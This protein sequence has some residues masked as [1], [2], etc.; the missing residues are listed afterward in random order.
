[1]P[2]L[3]NAMLKHGLSL[4]ILCFLL[5]LVPASA[6][7]RANDDYIRADRLG[8]AHISSDSGTSP[9]RYEQALRLGAGWNRWPLYWDRVERVPGEREWAAYDEQVRNDLEMGLQINAILIGVPGA[10]Q[11]GPRP[12]GI[13]SRSSPM[14]LTTPV[15]ARR[16]TRLTP[17]GAL[18]MPPSNAIN[19]AGNSQQGNNSHLGRA[20]ACGRSGTNRISRCSGRGVHGITHD[21][22]R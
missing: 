8:I 11:D 10:Y 5:A 15:P 1:M 19:R 22:S 7:Q 2:N 16:S 12:A 20:S 21:C 17:G 6:E 18:P 4:F 13:M 3:D 9:D 14:A